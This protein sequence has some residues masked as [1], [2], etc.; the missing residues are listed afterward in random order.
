M[1]ERRKYPRKDLVIF[2]NVY[3]PK[4]ERIIGTLLNITPDGAMVLSLNKVD[5]DRETELHIKLPE[6]FV[7][8]QELILTA[9]SRWCAPDIN[10]EFFDVGYQF[11][12]VSEEDGQIILKI[13]EKYGYKD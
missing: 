12:N 10:P 3:D 4:Y 1:Q 11:T 8:K 9:K 6:N 7:Q 2:T 5:S 13:I